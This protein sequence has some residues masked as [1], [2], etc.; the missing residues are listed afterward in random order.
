MLLGSNWFCSVCPLKWW[1]CTN[2]H[3]ASKCLFSGLSSGL[4]NTYG[5]SWTAGTLVVEMDRV[6]PSCP[7]EEQSWRM[8]GVL[9]ARAACH[10]SRRSQC[11]HKCPLSC[12][13]T[14]TVPCSC[15]CC[16]VSRRS[17]CHVFKVSGGFY[18]PPNLTPGAAQVLPTEEAGSE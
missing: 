15:V 18:L 7:W 4:V 10:V 12:V 2:I 3:K 14:I 6:C 9:F 8:V 17:Q 13:Q 1:P 16:H 11:I 5:V